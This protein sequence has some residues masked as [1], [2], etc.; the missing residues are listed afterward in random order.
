M[1][2]FLSFIPLYVILYTFFLLPTSISAQYTDCSGNNGTCVDPAVTSCSFGSPRYS[3]ECEAQ[4]GGIQNLVCCDS[5]PLPD[6]G[7]QGG[8]C[9]TSCT[10][11]SEVNWGDTSCYL[12]STTHSCCVPTSV[13]TTGCRQTGAQCC[14]GIAGGPNYCQYPFRCQTSTN[15]CYS[16]SCTLSY[17]TCVFPSQ[18]VPG[19]QI[20]LPPSGFKD[21]TGSTLC[22]DTQQK[23][24]YHC[25]LP[26]F[27][28][29]AI[30]NRPGI[31]TPIGCL[32]YA[33]DLAGADAGKIIVTTLVGWS[34]NLTGGLAILS[35]IYGAFL[36]ATARGD[37]K[38]VSAGREVISAALAGLILISLAVVFLNFLGIKVLNL[39]SLGFNV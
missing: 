37:L 36:V 34:V 35:L 4:G 33:G 15:I 28:F 16:D 10:P 39:G 25:T 14:P 31:K 23:T 22:C 6:C 9:K 38:R 3:P 11:T 27:C 7:N 20:A 29:T 2:K 24:D 12:T 32:P 13:T 26:I 18:C 30:G 8:T 21:C 1:K 17:G 5:A 19:C